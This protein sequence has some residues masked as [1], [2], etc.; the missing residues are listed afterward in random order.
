MTWAAS[1]NRATCWSGF[2]T[3][4]LRVTLWFFLKKIVSY[5]VSAASQCW[6]LQPMECVNST[7]HTSHFL[8]LACP[9]FWCHIDIG[10][11]NIDIA[12]VWRAAHISL[13]PI[14][15]RLWCCLFWLSSILPSTSS[16][17]FLSYHPVHSPGLQLLLPWCGRQ[18][19]RTLVNV[20]ETETS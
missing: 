7:P 4:L 19:P 14:F 3:K 11:C 16:V 8:A 13:H 20:R 18:V 6:Y 9:T 15:M 2:L 17:N 12:Q 10:E 1:Q 5:R